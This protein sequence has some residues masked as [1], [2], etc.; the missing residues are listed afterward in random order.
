MCDDKSPTL[1]LGKTPNGYIFGGYTSILLNYKK[2][3]YLRDD[4]AFVFSLNQKKRF[5]SKDKGHVINKTGGY[6][7]IFGNGSN[8]LQITNNILT[9]KKHWSN[10]N[11]SY[12]DNLNLTE[13]K[14]FAIS[15]FEVFHI[16][17]K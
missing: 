5:F 4:E 14:N 13:D 12:G 3:T 9:S 8:S 15:E 1:V 6:F 10:P 2:D 11:G 7:I 16:N 17:Q